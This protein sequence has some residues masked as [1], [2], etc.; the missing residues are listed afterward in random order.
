M[1]CAAS[2]SEKAPYVRQSWASAFH[3]MTMP[4][5]LAM[6]SWRE[7][8]RWVRAALGPQESGRA[9]ATHDHDHPDAPSGRHVPAA[10]DVV[11]AENVLGPLH[12]VHMRHRELE[13]DDNELDVEAGI[14]AA[15][16]G[17]AQGLQDGAVRGRVC[18]E[19]SLGR[20]PAAV[21]RSGGDGS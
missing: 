2:T 7:N 17:V 4:G 19:G 18:G 11:G 13:R 8:G 3:G 12:D 16:A 6:P 5:L 1:T 10:P 20:Q 9:Q 14:L 21:F 15:V